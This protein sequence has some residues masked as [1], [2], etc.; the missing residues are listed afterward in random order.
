[1]SF[2]PIFELALDRAVGFFLASATAKDIIFLHT[3]G[4]L[5]TE[6]Q[7]WRT[8]QLPLQIQKAIAG[9]RFRKILGKR[10]LRFAHAEVHFIYKA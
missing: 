6:S 1:V 9:D 4:A 5:C 7:P 3:F 2:F 10:V 8:S